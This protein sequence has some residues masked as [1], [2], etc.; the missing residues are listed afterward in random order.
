MTA[1]PFWPRSTHVAGAELDEI[2][3]ERRLVLQVLL[4]SPS[5]HAVERRLGDEEVAALDQVL[6]VA[7]EE[8]EQQ[9]ADV[10]AVDVGVG[11]QD[12]RCGSAA[13]RG[14]CPRVRCPR[15]SAVISEL[16][17][18]RR[19][20]LVEARLLDVEDLAA[21]RQDG[22]VLPV[23]ALLRRAA[24]RVALDDEQLRQRRI[25]LL[26]VGQLAGQRAAVERALA[27][28][29]LLRLARRLADARRLDAL[30]RRSGVASAGC[31]SR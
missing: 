8:G 2:V 29:Q 23:A 6:E 9:R 3:L 31:S 16:D 19:E 20:H 27:A 11:H 25:A 12:D 18:L 28:R 26:A 30:Q 7:V 10:R 15:P 24:G 1:G 13:W 4:R 5:L 21:Q 22:L 17:L 14:P